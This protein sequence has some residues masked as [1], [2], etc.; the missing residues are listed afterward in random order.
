MAR[1]GPLAT[2]SEEPE[3]SSD[4]EDSAELD[5]SDSEELDEDDEEDGLR[6]RSCFVDDLL[7]DATG[8]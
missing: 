5:E 8:L 1:G 7:F 6:R 3:S 4:E 2:E